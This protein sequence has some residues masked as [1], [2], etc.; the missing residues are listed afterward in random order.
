M[1]PR[2]SARI[3]DLLLLAA[4]KPIPERVVCRAL[5]NSFSTCME[6]L[7]SIMSPAYSKSWIPTSSLTLVLMLNSSD[8]F[9]YMLLLLLWS[10]DVRLSLSG[11][12]RRSEIQCEI[13]KSLAL[14]A[15]VL[16]IKICSIHPRPIAETRQV[17]LQQ[18][19]CC[20]CS[21]L[22]QAQLYSRTMPL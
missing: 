2:Y 4:D 9:S 21:T 3:L 6:S 20:L 10:L 7:T 17:F 15:T 19:F 18:L 8:T 12:L 11:T 1:H 22:P 14:S 13:Q 16:R 5:R